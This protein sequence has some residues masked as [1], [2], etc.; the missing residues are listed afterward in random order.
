MRLYQ[1]FAFLAAL[2]L[3]GCAVGPHYSPPTVPVP[4]A[5][6]EGPEGTKAAEPQDQL[7]R[8]KWWEV[9]RDPKLNSLE[10]K[11][12]V[13]NQNLKAALAQFEQAR[14]LVRV[15]R[16]DLYPTLTAGAAGS[17]N[18]LSRNRAA[19][20][21]LS[22]T[23]FSD[24]QMPTLGVSYEPDLFGR[25]R[26]T[27]ESARASGQASAGDVENVSLSLHAEL[28]AEYFQLRSLDAEEELLKSSVA[29]FAKALE[30]TE[31]RYHG[32]VS[33]AVDVA[34]AETELETTRAQA[35][36][37]EVARA[38]F[39]D[40]IALLVGQPASSF[41]IPNSPLAETP[42]VIPPG[43][44]SELL[45]RRPDIA[46]AERRV[47]AANEQV[48]VAHAAYFPSLS[49]SGSAGFESASLTNLLS[50]P[51]GFFALGASAL[52]TALDVGRRRGV[53]E[54]ARAI[55]QQSAANYRQTIL[56][57]FREVEDNLAALR[58]LAQEA[59]TQQA[60]VAAAE[61]SLQ[62]ST[63]RYKGGVAS[64]LEV[65]TA[66]AI[67]LSD[68]RVAVEIRGRRM[69]ASVRLIQ[70][71]GGGWNRSQLPAGKI[72]SLPPSATGQRPAVLSPG[73]DPRVTNLPLGFGLYCCGCHQQ[74]GTFQRSC[75]LA[76]PSSPD[77]ACR[78]A[79]RSERLAP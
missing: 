65:T 53:S 16:A 62:L 77:I 12:T 28:A 38:Q 49:L 15:N 54:E 51:S 60:A 27:I 17:R 21:T 57:A 68:E 69:S 9:Y 58:I 72:P 29:I 36:E 18:H 5:Y 32:G 47:A 1:A 22:R 23:N 40:S 41:S 26:H 37:I 67:A 19:A 42:P 8:G 66:Q 48:G 39:E 70:S 33:S 35:T 31:N 55:Y 45:E 75:P 74:R 43:L 59:E 46:A 52:V 4:P 79:G 20:T 11:I 76:S 71:L 78:L 30:L 25:V 10:E 63:S 3:A 7:A 6:K 44:P 56:N 2:A 73:N 13:S 14:A 34:Q 24:L 50:A 64:Y 61:H